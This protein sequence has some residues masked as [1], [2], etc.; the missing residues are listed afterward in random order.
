MRADD[1]MSSPAVTVTPATPAKAAI[2]LLA[3][4]GFTALPVVEDGDRLVGLVT[5]ADLLRGRVLP[6]A[7]TPHDCPPDPK[8]TV[9]EVMTAHPCRVAPN[10]DVARVAKL[11]LDRGL[12]SVPVTDNGR[13]VG[14]LTR[15]DLLRVLARDDLDILAE[16]R[17]KLAAYGG[18]RR[19]TVTVA[20]GA[21]T[22]LDEHDD[23][24]DRHVARVLAESVPGVQA[25]TV[26]AKPA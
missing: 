6:D 5:E 21:V 12:R 7:R 18:G 20:D 3:A 22:V 16:L 14:M 15:R 1:L 11:M 2:A 23:P 9:G 24:A 13:L 25:V 8:W 4:H 17:R 26:A 10:A 19:W